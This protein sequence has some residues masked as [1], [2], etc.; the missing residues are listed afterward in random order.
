MAQKEAAFSNQHSAI[1]EPTKTNTNQRPFT[2]EDTED[3]GRL[4]TEPRHDGTGEH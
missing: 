2:A 4:H 1:S 3:R